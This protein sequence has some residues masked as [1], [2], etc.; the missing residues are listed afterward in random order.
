ML[1]DIIRQ[2]DEKFDGRP[3]QTTNEDGRWIA[4]WASTGVHKLIGIFN[5]SELRFN[6]ALNNGVA[7]K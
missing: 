7:Y 1:I 2:P 4:T 5:G 3:A 6:E